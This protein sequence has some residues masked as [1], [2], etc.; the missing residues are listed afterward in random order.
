MT[1]DP[2]RHSEPAGLPARRVAADLLDGVLRRRRALDEL[3][4]GVQTPGEFTRLPER[5]RALAR[6][7]V[8]TALRRLGSLRYVLDQCLDHGFPREAPRVE[9]ALL[10]GATQLLFLDVPDHAAVDLAVRLAQSDRRAARYDRLVNAVLR[11]ITRSGADMLAGGD[12]LA[13]DTPGWLMGRWSRHYGVETA[14]AIALANRSEPPLDLTVKADR[15]GWA[16]RLGATVLPTGSLRLIPSGPISQLP[17]YDEGAWWVQDAAAALPVRLFGDITGQAIA[18]LC[19]APGGKSAQLASRGARV[20]AVDRSPTRLERV[21]ENL[22]RLSLTAE[23]V[24]EDASAWQGGSFDAVLIDAPCSSTGTI[25]R[26]PDIAWLKQEA[27]LAGL[28]KLQARLLRHAVSLTKPGGTIV[29]CTCSL[30]PEEGEELTARLLAEET[31][32]RR[33][34]IEPAEVAGHQELLTATGELRALPC[35]FPAS[36]P[37]LG[38]LDGFY[39]V[40]LVRV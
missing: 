11:R 7:I 21:R 27:D 17:G 31:G 16:T 35:H 37:R 10:V 20:T 26:H 6:Q 24:L 2:G 33:V 22:T 30:E 14:R 28:A 23:I 25:R 39:A 19:A 36:E 38:G 15:Q 8:G 3:L 1:T 32:V 18:D 9:T 4:T 40:R 34:P 12:T 5:D 29:F 13:L